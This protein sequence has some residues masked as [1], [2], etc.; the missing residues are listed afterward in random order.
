VEVHQ[1]EFLQAMAGL[2]L[3]MPLPLQSPLTKG[4]VV[5]ASWGDM[6][7]PQQALSVDDSLVLPKDT[8]PSRTLARMRLALSFAMDTVWEGTSVA[9][10][11]ALNPQ[12]FKLM[13]Y[14]TM[15]TYLL[16]L[17]MPEPVTKG[18]AAALTVYL[19]AYLGFGPRRQ[20]HRFSG[21]LPKQAYGRT[22]ERSCFPQEAD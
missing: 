19:V 1:E 13:V 18:L 5:L 10:S 9:L 17:M 7:E 14:T 22:P 21:K 20:A 4:W 2:V 8:L 16:L 11:E 12:A 3:E 6:E 15:S